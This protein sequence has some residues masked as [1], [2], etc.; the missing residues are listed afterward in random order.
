ML[1]KDLTAGQTIYALLKGD[2]LKYREGSIVTVGQPRME[3]PQNGGQ[4]PLQVP[5]LRNVVD[6]TYT[7][8]GKNYTDVV[9]VSASVF[10]TQ[11]TGEVTL[12]ATEKDAV[13]KELHATLRT[14]ENYLSEAEKN[15]PKQKKRVKEC[16]ALIAQLDTVFME[17][18]QTEERFIK[19]EETQKEQSSKLDEILKVIRKLAD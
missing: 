17:K 5:S 18:Q 10:S 19:L 6:V 1:F 13:V 12:V 4:M 3:M 15:V 7:I 14:S 16:K 8:D 11:N 9:D 2:E